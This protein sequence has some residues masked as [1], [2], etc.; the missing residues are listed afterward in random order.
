M[1]RGLR[2]EAFMGEG[3]RQGRIDRV[4]VVVGAHHEYRR[5]EGC[6]RRRFAFT[7]DPRELESVPEEWGL[8]Y[9][10]A[11]EIEQGL[12][13]GR[14]KARL[15]RWVWVTM[16]RR[17]TVIERRCIR[18][19]FLNA[20]SYREAGVA[21]GRSASSVCRAVWRGIGK[22]RRAALEEGL[23]GGPRRGRARVRGRGRSGRGSRLNRPGGT[24]SRVSRC[25]RRRSRTRR[26]RGS[27]VG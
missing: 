17:L 23:V 14:R 27:G 16:E 11:A 12:Y 13:W 21:L 15:L 4:D 6:S 2:E 26:Y 18:L 25:G 8:W 20:M 19:H 7:A 1:G 10:S 22:L 9:E 24:R 5:R 3:L